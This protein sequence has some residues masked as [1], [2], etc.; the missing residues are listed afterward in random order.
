MTE[1]GYTT[2]IMTVFYELLEPGETVT[3]DR[4]RLQL[5]HLYQALNEK[6]PEYAKTH[7]E[8]I[9]QHN[10]AR[11]H[12]AHEVKSYLETLGW[13]VWPQPPYSPDVS[14]SH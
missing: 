11:L 12:I 8:V 4:Y 10:R 5:M 9:F 2:T 1:S 13:N 6:R 3:D 14:P 7:D